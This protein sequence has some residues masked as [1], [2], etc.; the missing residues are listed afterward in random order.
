MTTKNDGLPLGEDHPPRKTTLRRLSGS[1]H[2]VART[3]HP[4]GSHPHGKSGYW[5]QEAA[6]ADEKL[7]LF[8]S[9][10]DPF[11]ASR[12][13]TMLVLT[14]KLGEKVVIGNGITITV[15]EVQGNRVRVGIEAPDDVRILRAELACWVEK[16]A[17][18]DEPADPPSRCGRNNV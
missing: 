3:A 13:K 4:F 14:R 17:E 1:N 16:P 11:P 18:S 10:Y 6:L 9:R 2:P 5:P 8:A 15:V 12:R 7:E